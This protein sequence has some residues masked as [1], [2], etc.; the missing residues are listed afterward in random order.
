[1][2]PNASFRK[3]TDAQNIDFAREQG[4]GVLAV[5]TSDAPLVSHIP[6]L[7]SKDG[8]LAEFHLVRSNPIARAFEDTAQGAPGCAGRAFLCLARLV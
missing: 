7:L 6:F 5:T 1:M 3:E 4:F 2:H 8:A